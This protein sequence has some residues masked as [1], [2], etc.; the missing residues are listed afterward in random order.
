VPPLAF[1]VALYAR[2][3]WPVGSDAPAEIESGVGAGVEEPPQ[4]RLTRQSAS[5]KSKNSRAFHDF[6]AFQ[7][8]PNGNLRLPQSVDCTSNFLD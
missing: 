8:N 2:F 1:S 4:P 7:A 3:V 5:A 6:I